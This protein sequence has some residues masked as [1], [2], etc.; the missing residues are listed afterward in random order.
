MC[1]NAQG[2]FDARA[3]RRM[4]QKMPCFQ[5]KLRQIDLLPV[6][7]AAEKL[8]LESRAL[9]GGKVLAHNVIHKNCAELGQVIHGFICLKIERH[10][11]S[12]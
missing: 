11:V 2:G 3:A 5:A 1:R 6:L 9:P 10:Q 4:C 7:C 12:L 8:C